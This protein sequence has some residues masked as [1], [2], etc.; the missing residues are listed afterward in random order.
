MDPLSDVLSLLKPQSYGFRGLDAA[1]QWALRYQKLKGVRCYMILSGACW[2]IVEGVDEPIHLVAGDCVLLT[3]TASFR[4]ASDL[5]FTSEMDAVELFS[6]TSEGGVATIRGGGE[7]T[8]IGGYYVFG[9]HH[10]GVLLALLP[11]V[12]H[13]RTA[14]RATF[15]WTMEMMMRELREPQPGGELIAQH[16]G[17][18]M[19]ILALRSHLGKGLKAGVGWLFA[20]ADKQLIAAITAMHSDPSHRWT[21]KLL[22]E[23]ASMSRSTF[24]LKFREAVGESPM[25]YLARWRMMLAGDRLINSRNTVSTIAG[26][27]GYESE[28]AF[29]AAFRRI[30]GC[31]PRQYTGSR[32][33]EASS[34][35]D[36]PIASMPLALMPD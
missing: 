36:T 13:I 27:L 32:E 34:T 4:L 7:T 9:G 25:E 26:S 20:L 33:F 1:G 14:D 17:H 35:D 28:S 30:M 19:L 2:L 10:E 6:S 12:V 29:S 22:A 11:P 18:T 8:G 5:T 23:R 21:L 31:S 3:T 15:L 24:A 16:L